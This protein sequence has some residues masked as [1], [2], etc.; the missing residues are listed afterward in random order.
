MDNL[1]A[2]KVEDV[3]EKRRDISAQFRANP[4]VGQIWNEFDESLVT[5]YDGTKLY[6]AYSAEYFFS[7]ELLAG[8]FVNNRL[9]A[10]APALLTA[11]GVIGTFAGLQLGL[12]GINLNAESD[13]ISEQIGILIGGAG[14][15]A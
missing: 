9:L 4:Q 1:D 2:I 15:L 12:N 5:S 3:L 8:K 7:Y 14:F 10:S 11:I 13:T 6:N